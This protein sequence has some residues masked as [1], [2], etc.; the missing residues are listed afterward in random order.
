MRDEHELRVS[1]HLLDHL[2]EPIDVGIVKR[3]VDFV[4]EAEGTR[5][6]EEDREQKAH[7]RERFFAAG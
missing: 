4:E 1:A 7:R 3:R 2:D 5:L 6:G